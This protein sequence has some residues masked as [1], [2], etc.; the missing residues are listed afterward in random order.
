MH[1][2]FSNRNFCFVIAINCFFAGG[3]SKIMI[4]FVVAGMVPVLDIH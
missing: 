2:T 4:S 3:V 1:K